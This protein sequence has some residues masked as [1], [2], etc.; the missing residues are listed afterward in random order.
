VLLGI[1]SHMVSRNLYLPDYPIGSLIAVQLEEQMA[2]SGHLG[3]EFTRMAS[4][5]RVT[6]DLWME[7]ATGSPVSAE[8]LLTSARRALDQLQE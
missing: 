6:P 5:G 7:N 4:F 3:A 8:P 2:K 1:Y